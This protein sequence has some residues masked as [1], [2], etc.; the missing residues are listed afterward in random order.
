MKV[1]L[2]DA[3]DLYLLCG[4]CLFDK[5]SSLVQTSANKNSS[6]LSLSSPE[7]QCKVLCFNLN[8]DFQMFGWKAL[9]EAIKPTSKKKEKF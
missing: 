7:F 8:N 9:P 3:L 1:D 4:L 2:L 5:L 6:F